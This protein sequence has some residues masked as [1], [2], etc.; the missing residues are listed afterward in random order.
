LITHGFNPEKKEMNNE[1]DFDT[2]FCPKILTKSC[3][4]YIAYSLIFNSL[5]HNRNCH[6]FVTLDLMRFIIEQV[7]L[8][9]N[10]KLIN[11]E[12]DYS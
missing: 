6:V 2:D 7:Y 1:K 4:E 8:A 3:L 9:S 10:I 5:Y 11:N 12:K